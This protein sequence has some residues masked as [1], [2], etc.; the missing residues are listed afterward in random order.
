MAWTNAHKQALIIKVVAS[1][2]CEHNVPIRFIIASRPEVAIHAAF[3]K[4][5]KLLAVFT[6]I[7]VD[8]DEDAQADIRQFIEDSF[9][10]IVSSHPLGHHITLP[11]PSPHSIDKIVW[12]SSGHFIY[13][14]TVMKFIGSS[15]EHPGCALKAVEGL[16]PSR[17]GSTFAELDSLYMHILTSATYSSQ[18]LGILRHRCL[19]YLENSVAAVCSIYD[20]SPEDVELFLSDVQSLVSSSPKY[21]TGIFINIKHASLR[22]FLADSKQSQRF[23]IKRDEYHASWL[24][25]Y[26]QLL[27]SGIRVSSDSPSLSER[28]AFINS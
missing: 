24:P 2:L 9:L 21:S 11:W 6:S 10:D 14:A 3:Q 4:E 28:G 23:Y 18:V 16:E 5:T 15:S 12:K 22:D 7:S 19:T 27:D 13:A 17:I 1:L 25:R 26:F 20:I 8:V